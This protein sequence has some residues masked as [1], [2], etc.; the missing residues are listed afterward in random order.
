MAIPKKNPFAENFQQALIDAGYPARVSG[1]W[2]QQTVDNMREFAK[3][4]GLAQSNYPSAEVLALLEI[5]PSFW[6]PTTQISGAPQAWIDD[7]KK[8]GEK[9]VALQLAQGVTEAMTSRTSGGGRMSASGSQ[10]L[11]GEDR[12][13][14]R[15]YTPP[16]TTQTQQPSRDVQTQ[17]DGQLPVDTTQAAAQAGKFEMPT[18]GWITIGVGS[19]FV[20]GGVGYAIWRSRQPAPAM[21]DWDW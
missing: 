12:V 16:A 21:S 18:W 20:I 10:P 5:D 14:D 9:Q 19:L 1:E 17:A 8:K 11:V 3:D 7:V 13:G 4:Y 6:Y 15:S 2:D